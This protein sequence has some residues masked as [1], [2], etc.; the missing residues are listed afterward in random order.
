MGQVLLDGAAVGVATGLVGAGA[1]VIAAA[2]GLL[3]ARWKTG[4]RPASR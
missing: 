3:A 2:P 1:A 4:Q